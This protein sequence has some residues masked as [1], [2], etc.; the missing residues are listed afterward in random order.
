M[1]ENVLIV[2]ATLAGL[3]IFLSPQLRRWDLWRATITPLASIIG[4]GFLVLGPVLNDSYGRYAPLAMAGLCAVAWVFGAAIRANI[5][6][7]AKGT[8]GK[9]RARFEAGADW[10]LALAY[11]VSVAYYLNLFGAFAVGL[12]P[13]A[14]A[15]LAKL[16]TTGV[17]ITILFV[18]WTRGFAAL[19]RMELMSVSLKLAIILGLVAG[20]VGDSFAKGAAGTFALGPANLTGWPALTLAFGLIV[21]VQGFETSRYLG[22]AY[23][24]A[25]R[26]RSMRLAQGAST[27]IYV[28]YVGLLV[29]CFAPGAGPTSETAIIGMMGQVAPVLPVLLVAAALAA[30]FSA[31]VADTAGAGGLVSARS[32]G[33]LG[34]RQSYAVLVGAGLVLTWTTGVF[35]IIAYAS[36]AFAVYYAAQC[37]IAAFSYWRKNNALSAGYASFAVLALAMALLG[38]AVE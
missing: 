21:T 36:R 11:I 18:G 20:L 1:F 7:L 34:T 29:L 4:S 2:L 22:D 9:N 19:E 16:V 8:P 23:S 3:I 28:V 38:R 13:S 32:R 35:G 30:Q 33:R 14:P 25:V 6:T 24:P 37:A 26:I 27:L 10:I 17:Y 5:A 31:A 12:L 15:Y